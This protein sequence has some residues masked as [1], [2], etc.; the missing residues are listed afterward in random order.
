MQVSL[1]NPVNDQV[2]V[3]PKFT[4]SLEG[5]LWDVADPNVFVLADNRQFYVYV[6]APVRTRCLFYARPPLSGLAQRAERRALIGWD[7]RRRMGTAAA[8]SRRAS[9]ARYR[10]C[11]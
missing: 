11:G 2:L 4:G 8:L 1:F 5:A 9:A 3:I 6:Y 10:D 7:G